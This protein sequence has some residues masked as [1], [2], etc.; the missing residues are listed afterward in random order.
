MCARSRTRPPPVAGSSSRPSTSPDAGT[1]P[2][3]GT[4]P[5]ADTRSVA[6]ASADDAARGRE[7]RPGL[8][9]LVYEQRIAATPER[10][11]E[12][13]LSKDG[14]AQWTAPFSPGS[15][16]EGTWTQGE[17]MRFLAPGGGGMVAEIAVVR[18]A[19]F[20]SIK[21]LGYVFGGTED[22]TSAS[23]QSWA[24]AYEEYRLRRDG[25]ETVVTVEHEVL[26]AA[27]GMMNNMWP[28]AL[29]A[30]KDLCEAGP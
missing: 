7:L 28:M 24:P 26:A 23:V 19:E 16:F 9:R 13:M 8:E 17:R 6:E 15:Y 5:D 2:E 21:H 1:P 11:W 22:T 4:L 12:R 14:Y 3:A 20:L 25:H 30:L 10:V 27:K 29:A 18:P